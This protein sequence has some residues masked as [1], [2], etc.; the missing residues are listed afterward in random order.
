MTIYLT[1]KQ[2]EKINALAIQRYSPNEKIQTVSSSALNMIVNLPEQFVFGKSLYPTIF[3]KATILF[4]QLI[5]KHVF[6]NA[7]KRTAFFVRDSNTKK[8]S[9][10]EHTVSSLSRNFKVV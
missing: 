7:N 10:R 1:E 9:L 8:I 2:I 4:V 3:D 6:A 5:K